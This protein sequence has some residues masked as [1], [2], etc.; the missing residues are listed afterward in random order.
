[1]NTVC[2][3]L[4]RLLARSSGLTSGTW[5][6][7][8][9]VLDFDSS[10][11]STTVPFSVTLSTESRGI[12]SFSRDLFF[13]PRDFFSLVIGDGIDVPTEDTEDIHI[14]IKIYNNLT[15]TYITYKRP[16]NS[17]KSLNA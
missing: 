9:T 16:D 6:L 1:M 15:N 2:V 7:K 14:N 12:L 5:N 8:V 11:H 13:D 3:C 17:L 10:W 4:T